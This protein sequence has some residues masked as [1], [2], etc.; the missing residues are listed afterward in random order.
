MWNGHLGGIQSISQQT[1]GYLYQGLVPLSSLCFISFSISML[2]LVNPGWMGIISPGSLLHF[3][4]VCVVERLWP[5]PQPADHGWIPNL[6]GV[7]KGHRHLDHANMTGMV[8]GTSTV[9]QQHTKAPSPA[10]DCTAARQREAVPPVEIRGWWCT[11]AAPCDHSH[12][13]SP[14]IMQLITHMISQ[15]CLWALCACLYTC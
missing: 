10:P 12:H 5:V 11:L 1:F 2:Q 4:P 13:K 3:L 7:I 6:A 14:L 9:R 15:E 8:P